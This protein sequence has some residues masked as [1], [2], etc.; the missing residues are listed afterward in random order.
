MIQSRI[1][2][3]A[4]FNIIVSDNIYF[5]FHLGCSCYSNE[6]KFVD[7]WIWVNNADQNPASS[8]F[9]IA[10]ASFEALLYGRTFVPEF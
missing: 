7:I 2:I 8:L 4:L 3:V 10:S 1:S 6:A 9:A 5:H